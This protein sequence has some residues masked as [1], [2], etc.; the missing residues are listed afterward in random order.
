VRGEKVTEVKVRE[1]KRWRMTEK[2]RE[3][4]RWRMKEKVREEGRREGDEGGVR[5]AERHNTL[6]ISPLTCQVCQALLRC[7]EQ[8]TAP[9]RI[10]LTEQS[11]HL[12]TL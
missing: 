1:E 7:P 11:D 2:V 4:K 8:H 5:V 12:P 9:V 10:T 3:E 6:N